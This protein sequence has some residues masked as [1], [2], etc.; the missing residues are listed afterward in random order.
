MLKESITERR[1]EDR[2][3]KT[4]NEPNEPKCDGDNVQ[5][6]FTLQSYEEQLIIDD[7]DNVIMS[8]DREFT[9]ARETSEQIET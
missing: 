5:L 8:S 4:D 9:K 7:S 3:V 6:N 2:H 1:I